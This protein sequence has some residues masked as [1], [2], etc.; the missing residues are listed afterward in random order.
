MNL[1]PIRSCYGTTHFFRRAAALSVVLTAAISPAR[2]QGR[3][4]TLERP[5]NTRLEGRLLGDAA[6]GFRFM[7]RDASK[8]VIP[9]AGSAIQLGGSGPDSLASP[10]PF[11][12]LVGE[13]LRLS[14]VLR[15]ISQESVRVGVR[16][17]AP[18]VVVRRPG[19]Q[20]L[21]QRPGEARVMVDG[22]ETIDLERWSKGGD[23]SLV[24][25]PRLGERKSLRLPARGAALLHRLDEPLPAGRFD[26]A[27][28]D[29]GTVAAGQHWFVELIYQ[30]MGGPAAVRVALGWSD[31]TLAVESPKGPSLAIQR[32]ARTPGWHRLTFRF[33]PD[34][35]EIAVD[36]KELAHGKG[37]DGPLVN[38]RLASAS[39]SAGTIPKDLAGHFDDLQLIRF[40]EPAVSPEIDISQ[41]EARFV[42]G[43]QLFGVIIHAGVDQVL[44]AV[45]GKRVTLPWSEVSGLHF[46]RVPA[47]G[48]PVEGLLVRVEWRAAPGSDPVDLDFAEGAL[49]GLSDHA[50]VL[51]TPYA[52]VLNLPRDLLRR[53][54]VLGRGRR[55]VIDPA[56]HHLGDEIS[57][58]APVH[59]PPQPEGSQLERE[60]V[61]SE[62]PE[63][64]ALLVLDVSQVEG[65]D[66]DS[67]FSPNVRRGELR[68]YVVLNGKRI[69]YLN[70]YI[71]T[72]D[73]SPERVAIPI[74]AGLLHAGKNTLRLELTGMANQAKE[75]DDIG[76]HQIA[77]EFAA[78]Q[79]AAP[80]P[81][82]R[83]GS[84]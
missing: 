7:P 28:F 71:K 36:G 54:V 74:P 80:Q 13:S 15:G 26:V 60:I 10:P 23:P 17:Q 3:V 24:E 59:D 31:E 70:R 30:G 64:P 79:K 58:T 77:L 43:D 41:D 78:V 68:T 16:W 75:L 38:I 9:E 4:E 69:D 12:V 39:T 11:R 49:Q 20:A 27:F 82:A 50:L 51:A 73:E 19:V 76:V 6:A 66:N 40:A 81:A 18:E 34:Q 62:L 52:G 35:T 47:A 65:E 72:R 14:G 63:L 33:G 55:L 84:P 67:K 53:L 29:N 37:P 44:M 46:R 61:L 56:S 45:G 21:L 22:F 8:P 57:V 32:L 5:D 1:R 2:G 48:A 83:P 42:T 25:E